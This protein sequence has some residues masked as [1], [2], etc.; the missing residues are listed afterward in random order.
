MRLV[1]Y[2]IN[3]ASHAGVLTD[4]GIVP[5]SAMGADLPNDVLLLVKGGG[6]MRAK[7][8]KAVGNGVDTIDPADVRLEAPIRVPARNIFCVGKNYTEHAKEFERSGFDAT[9]AGQ[10]TPDL[11]IVFTKAPSSVSGPTD[12]ID[13]TMDPTG[14]IDYEGEL[15][16]VIGT[17]GRGIKAADAMKHIFGYTVVNDVTSREMQSRHKQ[18]FLGKSPDTFCPMGPA[19]VTADEIDDVAKMRLTTTVNGEVRQDA[20]VRDLI[21]DIPTI[22]ETI[23]ASITLQPG[24]IIATGTP[25]GVAVGFNPP[26]YLKAGDVVEVNIDPIGK[27]VNV[28]A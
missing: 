28:V 22:I 8:E 13:S 4:A 6:E 5:V 9:S 27:I 14:T 18:W 12:T 23:S 25:A 10:A 24:D 15:A 1:T 11:P 20:L 3:G 16:V 26:K 19:L 17:G 21:F 2:S 7:L